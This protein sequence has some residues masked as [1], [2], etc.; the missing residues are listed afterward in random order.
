[1][2]GVAVLGERIARFRKG[3]GL[4][5]RGFTS[6]ADAAAQRPQQSVESSSSSERDHEIARKEQEKEFDKEERKL[7]QI[8]SDRILAEKLED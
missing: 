1:M 5:T 3:G 8:V 2:D 7:N 4:P 6:Y